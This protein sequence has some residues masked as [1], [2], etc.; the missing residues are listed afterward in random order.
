ME[1][2]HPLAIFDMDGVLTSRD[3]LTAL[4][5]LALGRRPWRLPA[6]LLSLVRLALNRED[7]DARIRHGSVIVA[8][9]FSGMDERQLENDARALARRWM[10]SPRRVRSGG[11]AAFL[12]HASAGD[13]VIVATASDGRVARAVAREIGVL[14]TL[15]ISSAIVLTG[16][17]A[18]IKPYSLGYHKRDALRA[19]G[20]ELRTARFYTDSA[21]DLPTARECGATVLIHP[22]SRTLA[23]FR[24]AGVGFDILE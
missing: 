2:R 16:R 23:R 14:P 12:D 22:T 4:I 7:V 24:E 18:E 11:V 19:A 15:V 3:T 13:T 17:T 8:V 21:T 6:I 9:A 20:V 10:V 5:V 1:T